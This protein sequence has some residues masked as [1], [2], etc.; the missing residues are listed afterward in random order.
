MTGSLTVQRSTQT[1]AQSDRPIA[2]V[3]LLELPRVAMPS[4]RTH[5]DSQPGKADL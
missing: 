4:D 5:H 2:L 3:A 1:G